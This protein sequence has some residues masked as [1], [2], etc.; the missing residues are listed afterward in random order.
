MEIGVEAVDK[1]DGE[2]V[3]F[4]YIPPEQK[5]TPISVRK[6]PLLAWSALNWA[7]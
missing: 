6:M 3:F 7:R 5:A 2:D 4:C 1:D